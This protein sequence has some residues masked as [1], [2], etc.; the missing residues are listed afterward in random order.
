MRI[1]KVTIKSFKRF[2]DLTIQGIPETARLVV[3]T[4]PNGCGKSSLFDAFLLYYRKITARFV[5]FNIDKDYLNKVGLPELVWDGLV[6]VSFYE[7]LPQEETQQRKLFYFRSAYR[8]EADFTVTNVQKIDVNADITRIQRL[9]DNDVNVSLNYQRLVAETVAF[10]YGGTRD[11]ITVGNL[12][13]ELIGQIRESMLRVFGDLVLKGPGNPLEDGT[14]FFTKGLS[15]NFRYK[16]LSGGEKAAFDL[17]LDFVVKRVSFSNTVFCIDEPETHMNTRLQSKLLDEFFKLLPENCQLWIATHSIGMMRRARDL[18]EANPGEVVF[19][20]F[21]EKDFDQPQTLEPHPVN[22][23]FWERTL[24]VALD[25][26]SD[27]VAPRRVVI[28]EGNIMGT[29]NP[30]KAE[31]D[32]QCYRTIFATE[33]P[34]TQFLSAGSCNEVEEDRFALIATIKALAKGVDIIRVVDKDDKSA[35]E[36]EELVTK[37][38]KVLSLRHIES[39]LFND[40]ILNL[41][42]VTSEKPD[43][44][45]ELLTTK[46]TAISKSINRGNA[47]DDIKSAGGDIYIAAKKLLNLKGAGNTVD[48]FCR[49]TLAPLVAPGTNVYA[50]LKRD[51]FGL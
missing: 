14:F 7:Q 2:H 6:D 32:A 48:A 30:K 12:R 33:F 11:G 21:D 10:V 42:C 37:D 22:R 25:D 24:R 20:D 23:A 29:G 18:Q 17:L 9:I 44:I 19:L 16:N 15:Q 35:K 34:D 13:E 1:N 5:G 28:C 39:Y 49:D 8:N 31:F 47:Q 38:V 46:Q 43:L 50:E 41:L 3:M 26:L 40:E 4:G 36:I 27:L 51:I 45:N